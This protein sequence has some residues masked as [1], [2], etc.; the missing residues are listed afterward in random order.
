MSEFASELGVRALCSHCRGCA[1]NP[2]S[3]SEDPT[4]HEASPKTKKERKKNEMLYF[5]FIYYFSNAFPF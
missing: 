2:W 1:F 3:G 5:T 4:S